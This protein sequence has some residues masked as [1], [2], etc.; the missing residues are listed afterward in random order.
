MPW[1]GL[2]GEIFC[3]IHC[4]TFRCYL[5]ISVVY[6]LSEISTFLPTKH[7][8]CCL[9]VYQLPGSRHE[10]SSTTWVVSFV[11]PPPPAQQKSSRANGVVAS[12]FLLE[13]KSKAT[14]LWLGSAA[15]TSVPS[16]RPHRACFQL[17]STVRSHKTELY[18]S[19]STLCRHERNPVIL[20][21]RSVGSI[22]RA[23]HLHRIASHRIALQL[24]SA[25]LFGCACSLLDREEVL[26]SGLVREKNTI[27]VGNLRS[28]TIKRTG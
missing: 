25:Y 13:Q 18:A 26:L 9:A 3:K 10:I 17:H 7:G 28:F 21:G 6:Q 11:R 8:L 14:R 12:V 19:T 23:L 22:D 27:L 15:F 24:L 16:D 1:A 20:L 2:D 5:T 4:S